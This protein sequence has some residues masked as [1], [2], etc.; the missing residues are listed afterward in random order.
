[1][2]CTLTTLLCAGALSLMAAA[3][4]A[5]AD[6]MYTLSDV[7]F[8]GG[9][10][11]SGYFDLNQYGYISSYDIVTTAG[12]AGF[13]GETYANAQ[14]NAGPSIDSAHDLVV[15]NLTG[16]DGDL[17]LAFAG[18]LFPPQGTSDPIVTGG[19]SF[20]CNTY[21]QTNGAC[22]PTSDER[23]IGSGSVVVPEPASLALLSTGVF[24][25]GLIR[26][27]RTGARKAT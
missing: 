7:T 24:G 15:F 21:A 17:T 13:P 26:R 1:M 25:L 4:P 12:V 16:Y 18:S 10:T 20:E 19:P 6:V 8:V 27:R 9:G 14:T 23:L 2:K 3:T 5:S 22:L 11:A